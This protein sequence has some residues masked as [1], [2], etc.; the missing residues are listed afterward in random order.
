M[1]TSNG[2]AEPLEDTYQ[3]ASVSGVGVEYEVR[4]SVEEPGRFF[5]FA[6]SGPA[7]RVM[8]AA[9]SMTAA[10]DYIGAAVDR[11]LADETDGPIDRPADAFPVRWP[12]FLSPGGVAAAG[13]IH[14]TVPTSPA[15]LRHYRPTG[16]TLCGLAVREGAYIPTSGDLASVRPADYCPRCYG[17]RRDER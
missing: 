12:V 14:A 5:V 13:M 10:L 7:A 16:G 17:D 15:G 3:V 11:E 4:A 1:T 9:P 8:A 2:T 6:Y